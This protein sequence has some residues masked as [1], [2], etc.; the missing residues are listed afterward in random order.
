MATL[1]YKTYF[2]LHSTALCSNIHKVIKANRALLSLDQY[3]ISHQ[4]R[5]SLYRDFVMLTISIGLVSILYG[6]FRFLE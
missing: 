4:V 3:P 6:I 5:M 2:Q 1:L